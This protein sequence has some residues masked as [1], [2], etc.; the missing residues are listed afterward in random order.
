MSSIRR[1]FFDA[2]IDNFCIYANK[3]SDILLMYAKVY[4]FLKRNAKFITAVFGKKTTGY[5]LGEK[6]EKDT[7]TDIPKGPLANRGRT[8]FFSLETFVSTLEKSGF[9]HI[10]CDNILYTDKGYTIEIL[11]ACCE[12]NKILKSCFISYVSLVP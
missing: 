12:K 8:H 2:V 3:Y 1:I 6:S 4:S 9:K 7:Y 10:Q 11:V 5:G